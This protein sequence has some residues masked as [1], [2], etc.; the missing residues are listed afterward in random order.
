VALSASG[1]PIERLI[2]KPEKP[3]PPEPLWSDGSPYFEPVQLVFPFTEK[4]A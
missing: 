1:S 2:A 4:G 3:K